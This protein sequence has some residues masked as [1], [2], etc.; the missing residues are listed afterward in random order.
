MQHLL[1]ENALRLP[2]KAM[3]APC[4]VWHTVYRINLYRAPS[5]T[6]LLLGMR[7]WASAIGTQPSPNK[8]VWRSLQGATAADAAAAKA[9]L[10]LAGSAVFAEPELSAQ[11]SLQALAGLPAEATGEQR[12]PPKTV[13]SELPW[14]IA[15]F[16]A[17]GQR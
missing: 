13:D 3:D 6:Q 14:T 11:Y 7:I 17:S 16:L 2:V 12:A 5:G 10:P 9:A 8:F 4:Q 1:Q 15:A